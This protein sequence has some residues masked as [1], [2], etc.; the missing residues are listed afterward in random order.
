MRTSS[1]RPRPLNAILAA[2]GRPET[3]ARPADGVTD[4][5]LR[6]EYLGL[7]RREDWRWAR[8]SWHWP[9]RRCGWPR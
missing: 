3:V 9:Y 5:F 6:Y 4:L 2:V 8:V 7:L 1:R